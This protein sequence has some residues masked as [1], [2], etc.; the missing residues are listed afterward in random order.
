[1]VLSVPP[2][3]GLN[4]HLP[5]LLLFA[6]FASFADRRALRFS[7]GPVVPWSRGPV[8][9][10]SRGPVVPWSR[11]PVVPWSR[12]PVVPWSRR[13]AVPWSRGPAVPSL[14]LC[15]ALTPSTAP[16]SHSLSYTLQPGDPPPTFGDRHH[17]G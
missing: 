1:M 11:G 2:L 6:P 3:R 12:G 8:V 7:R 9:P 5:F 16:A 14:A 10:W 15:F 4:R 17:S 13:P